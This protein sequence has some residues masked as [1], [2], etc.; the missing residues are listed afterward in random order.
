MAKKI[1]YYVEN[2]MIKNSFAPA[3]KHIPKWYKDILPEKQVA[4]EMYKTNVKNCM[5]FLDSYL[6]G[7][8]IETT[9]DFIVSKINDQTIFNWPLDNEQLLTIGQ[10]QENHIPA[11]EGFEQTAFIW[12]LIHSIKLPAGYSALFTHPLNR[13]DLPFYSLSGIVDLDEGMNG[14]SYPFFIKKNFEGI[15]PL[16][17]PIIQVIPFKREVWKSE[18]DESL[19]PLKEKASF[20]SAQVVVGWYKNKLWHKKS[21]D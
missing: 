3:K 14:G 17:T 5:P 15:I 7:Y 19:E 6:S 8:M 1:K 21:F 11:L 20:L 13:T 10:R 12:K 18:F 2:K 9:Q 4:G 16:G